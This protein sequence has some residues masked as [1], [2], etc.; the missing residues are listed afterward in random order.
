MFNH[1]IRLFLLD[2]MTGTF[3]EVGATVVYTDTAFH[4]FKRTRTL[5]D[6]PVAGA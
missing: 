4:R 3:D 5:M 1:S 2:P 6:T